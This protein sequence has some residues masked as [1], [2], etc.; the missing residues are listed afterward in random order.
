MT[1]E[2][3]LAYLKSVAEA[4]Q[5]A[6]PLAGRFFLWWGGLA[7]LALLGHWSVLAG[8]TG[9]EPQYVGVIWTGFGIVGTAGSALLRRGL[10]H[11]PGLGAVNVRAESAAWRGV[12]GLVIAYAIG[13]VIAMSL[14]RGHL[15][16][17]DTIPLVAVGGYGVACWVSAQLGGPRWMTHLA[18]ASWLA[19][20]LGLMLVGQTA[21][22]LF[23]AA[24]TALLAFLPGLILV[25]REPAGEPG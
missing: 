10:S 8:L 24:A 17:F 11:K 6:A 2:S 16:L 19:S 1:D 5:S 21:F 13:A 12:M 22:Y 15:I 23:A 7:C 9:I 14:G 25:R 20:G 4:G 18:F 3:D